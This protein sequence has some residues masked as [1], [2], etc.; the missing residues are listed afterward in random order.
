M[1]IGILQTGK[2]NASIQDEFNSYPDMFETLLDGNPHH[3]SFTTFDVTASILPDSPDICDGYIITGSSAGVYDDHVWLEPLFSF[4][5][6]CSDQHLPMV[7]ICFGHQA[8]AH[9]LGGTVV[10]FHDGWGVGNRQMTLHN[11]DQ[12]GTIIDQQIDDSSF[13][14]PYFHQDQVTAL[15]E[16]ATLTASNGFCQIGGFIMDTHILCFQGHPEFSSRYCKA[17]LEVRRESIGNSRT[18][19]AHASLPNGND[20]QK[21]G[22]WIS[23]FF[24]SHSGQSGHVGHA[25]N[26]TS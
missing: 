9:A 3:F 6:A 24:A 26:T 15:P 16:G 12:L 5:R 10:K 18:D 2:I 22:S 19:K 8:I 23:H 11:A 17:L 13:S 4:I 7:G 21:I 14:L 25:C 1:H 20:R